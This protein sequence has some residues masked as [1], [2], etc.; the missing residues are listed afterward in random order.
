MYTEPDFKSYVDYLRNDRLYD[1]NFLNRLGKQTQLIKMIALRH[2][3][4]KEGATEEE[5]VS[6]F[7]QK[8]ATAVE[9]KQP[10]KSPMQRRTEVT[11]KRRGRSTCPPKE[12]VVRPVPAA[13][14]QLD[15]SRVPVRYFTRRA[16]VET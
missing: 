12:R 14:M 7:T 11:P 4:H 8:L 13:L 3:Q 2:T 5:V 10:E 6:K 16:P 1:R 15:G 9:K